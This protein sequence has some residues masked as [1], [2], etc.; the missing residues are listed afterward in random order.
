MSSLQRYEKTIKREKIAFFFFVDHL[1]RL[2]IIFFSFWYVYT[3][4]GKDVFFISYWMLIL[5]VLDAMHRYIILA[6]RQ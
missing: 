3:D 6:H 4:E 5:Y 2:I 1:A